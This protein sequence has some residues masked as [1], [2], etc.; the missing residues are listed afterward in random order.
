[1]RECARL[2]DAG[3]LGRIGHA[4]FRLVNG[5]PERYRVDGVPGCSTRPSR[6]A[7]RLRNLG[8]HG[9]DCAAAL[10]T[11]ALRLVSAHVGRRLHDDE[12]VEDHALVSFTDEAGALFTV[13]AGYTYASLRPGGDFEWRIAAANATLIDR[14]D[15]AHASP[16]ST[17]APRR[18]SSL[19]PPT[20]AT[21][22]SC[23]RRSTA[24]PAAARRRSA[25]EDYARAMQLIDQA[26]GKRA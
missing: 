16:P 4:H 18:R 11:G 15:T 17:T 7:G 25:L 9:V 23:A 6:A 13:E 26:Y 22:P 8:I 19:W 24:S 3:R 2:R 20:F 5:P 10:A 14:G 21:A 1:M 12:A